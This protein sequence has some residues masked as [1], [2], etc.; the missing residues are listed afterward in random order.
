MTRGR[1]VEKLATIAVM[2]VVLTTGTAH[3]QASPE[4]VQRK[5]REPQQRS[6]NRSAATAPATAPAAAA[7]PRPSR[8]PAQLHADAVA[9]MRA[10][11]YAKAGVLLDQAI[12][13]S[14]TVPTRALVLN[15]AIVDVAQ[16]VNAMRA[17]KDVQ[18]WLA[19]QTEPD[20]RAVDV[21]CAAMQIAAKNP[22]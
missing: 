2:F 4:Q 1:A 19:G 12:D 10:G 5:L 21:Q 7:A 18:Q 3:G 6:A 16:K 9:L 8:S 17:V 15:R 20:E 22:R 13:A 11:Q 14:A